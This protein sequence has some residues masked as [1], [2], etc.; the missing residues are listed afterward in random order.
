MHKDNHHLSAQHIKVF[1]GSLVLVQKLKQ[2]LEK[3]GIETFIKDES[4]IASVTGFVDF[5]PV[6]LFILESDVEQAKPIVEAFQKRFDV[7]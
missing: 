6:Q 2:D 7:K 3:E 4:Y 1:S 5:S